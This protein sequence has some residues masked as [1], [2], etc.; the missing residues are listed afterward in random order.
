MCIDVSINENCNENANL[1]QAQLK[2][3]EGTCNPN[4]KFLTRNSTFHLAGIICIP[5]LNF[6]DPIFCFFVNI[7]NTD[8]QTIVD[9]TQEQQLLLL[10]CNSSDL[11]FHSGN[12]IQANS[13]NGEIEPKADVPHNTV[14]HL[15]CEEDNFRLE[16]VNE[17]RCVNGSFDPLITN[18]TQCTPSGE[19]L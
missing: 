8:T 6:T 4:T 19:I 15:S 11:L 18:T 10:Q 14:V 17:T 9:G 5:V 13:R 7:L 16:G 1:F 3:A 2:Y 12:D